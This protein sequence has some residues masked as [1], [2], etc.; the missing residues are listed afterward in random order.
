MSGS[1]DE[2][3]GLNLTL[4]GYKYLGPGNP[5]DSGEPSNRLDAIAQRHDQAYT[6]ISQYYKKTKDY[7]RF[8]QEIRQADDDFIAEVAQN[9]PEGIYDAAA[10]GAA[11]AGIAGKRLLE[12]V[13]GVQ[14]P[15]VNLTEDDDDM[16]GHEGPV[17]N[18]G[19]VIDGGVSN[20]SNNLN[21]QFNKKFNL[22]IKSTKLRYTKRKAAVGSPG[23]VNIET[24]VHSLPWQ[25]IWMYMTEKEYN[26]VTHLSHHA[27]ITKVS[28]KITNL[29]NRTPFVTGQNT[30]SYANANSQT[31]IGIWENMEAIGPVKM[32]T[33]I[34]PKILYG[35]TLKELP[36]QSSMA[37]MPKSNYGAT[38][39]AK[40][41]NN[42]MTFEFVTE[43]RT[44]TE[45]VDGYFYVPSMLMQA[46]VLYNATNSIGTIYQKSY[47]PKDGTFHRASNAWLNIQET[48]TASNTMKK[49][50][51]DTG[52]TSDITM[53]RNASSWSQPYMSATIENNIFG[54][55]MTSNLGSNMC[56]NGSL[57]IGILPLMNND[58]GLED[59]VLNFLLETHIQGEAYC[60][61]TN[62][63]MA[64]LKNITQ[65]NTNSVSNMC[66]VKWDDGFGVNQTPT[67][68][69]E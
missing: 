64:N 57:G 60:H 62:I 49:L 44:N 65:P 7:R 4:P 11:L 5:V 55:S 8:E 20:T 45:T 27:K 51:L 47:E 24:F 31:T 61:G 58:E 1:E 54:H 38:S 19:A 21:F 69:I 10:Q 53:N 3:D 35:S 66:K 6:R 50:R 18:A 16:E 14:Y 29:G 25:K 67:M 56:M 40:H 22:N 52:T 26:D 37:D 63:L 9:R 34:T 39:Q 17:G 46:G 33:N 30:V 42:P 59:S 2:D 28:I 41:I 68:T 15:R 43:S 48:I 36:E 13:V 12:S 23:V 32:G